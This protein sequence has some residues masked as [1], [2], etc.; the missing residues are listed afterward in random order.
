M[1]AFVLPSYIPSFSEAAHVATLHSVLFAVVAIILAISARH[2]YGP[3]HKRPP[4]FP[5]SPFLAQ[6]PIFITT[7]GNAILLPVLGL[8]AWLRAELQPSHVTVLLLVQVLAS[9]E[10]TFV[11]GG[12]VVVT[13]NLVHYS[14]T[15]RA[16]A[17]TKTTS[18]ECYAVETAASSDSA[19]VR[20]RS[21]APSREGSSASVTHLRHSDAD[22]VTVGSAV[23]LTSTPTV[24]LSQQLAEA[25]EVCSLLRVL[26]LLTT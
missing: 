22:A 25:V 2:V 1:L 4:F 3:A 17:P 5:V 20:R 26:L 23:P 18:I 11:L 7:I 19:A 14:K 6:L 15:A 9:L 24:A 16:A 10:S 8:E 21:A 13:Y 12:V